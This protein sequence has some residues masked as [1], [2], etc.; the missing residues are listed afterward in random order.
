MPKS[1]VFWHF[2]INENTPWITEK[3]E[4]GHKPKSGEKIETETIRN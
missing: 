3:V 2:A 4:Q 1:V